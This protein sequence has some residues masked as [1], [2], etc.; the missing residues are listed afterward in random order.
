MLI[1]QYNFIIYQPRAAVSQ[2]GTH[3]SYLLE[4]NKL[5][6][7]DTKV[8]CNTFIHREIKILLTVKAKSILRLLMD[9]FTSMCH[10]PKILQ[11]CQLWAFLPFCCRLTS[12]SIHSF[13]TDFKWC[14]KAVVHSKH[15]KKSVIF[16]WKK[17]CEGRS[18][19]PVRSRSRGSLTAGAALLSP[20]TLISNGARQREH[21]SK[22][23]RETSFWGKMCLELDAATAVR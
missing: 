21:T 15:Q 2:N 8:G 23:P 11:P 9:G 14:Q 10:E 13:I 1:L 19:C 12:A 22:P 6:K 16:Q 5:H 7:N 3:N 18:G 17:K 20:R 4:V